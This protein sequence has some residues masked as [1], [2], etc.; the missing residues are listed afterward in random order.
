M[1][2][3]HELIFLPIGKTLEENERFAN[4]PDC[5]ESLLMTLD[6]YTRVG[7]QPPWTSYYFQLEN[8]LVG[9]GA[10]KGAPVDGKVEIAYG[11]IE[12]F[13]QRG[14]GTAICK[15]LVN[16]SLKTDPSVIITA[17]TLPEPNFSTRILTR[18][19]FR[20]LGVVLDPEDGE[21]WEWLYEIS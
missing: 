18:N 16:L 19:N 14:I 20:N 12:R 1:N 4:H 10:F 17:R 6:F 21:V 15:A 13:R 5:R 2:E 7:F 11:T 3:N 8:E 9:M